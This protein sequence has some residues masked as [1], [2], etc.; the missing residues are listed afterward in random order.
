MNEGEGR[1]L[2][3]KKKKNKFFKLQNKNKNF[4]EFF[5]SI[6]SNDGMNGASEIV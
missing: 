3:S 5:I 4:M 1:N 6:D 2:N